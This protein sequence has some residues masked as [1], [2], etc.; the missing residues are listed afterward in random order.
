[1]IEGIL[2]R[3]MTLAE[4]AAEYEIT[5]DELDEYLEQLKRKGDLFEVKPNKYKLL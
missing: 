3:F 2:A 4:K 1:M 5:P